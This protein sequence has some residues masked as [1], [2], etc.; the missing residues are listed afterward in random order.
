MRKKPAQTRS[1]IRC[2][3]VFIPREVCTVT[4]ARGKYHYSRTLGISGRG[5]AVEG[6]FDA[7]GRLI[8]LELL[9]DGKK[10]QRSR[11]SSRD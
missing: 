4:L 5:D 6:E 3:R 9:G 10:C 8:G 7:K 1:K 11:R 2:I